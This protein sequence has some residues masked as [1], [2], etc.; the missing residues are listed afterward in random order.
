MM[1]ELKGSCLRNDG[2]DADEALRKRLDD[3]KKDTYQAN[4][5]R[6]LC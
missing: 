1:G 4:I 6:K 3:A 2:K 5:E